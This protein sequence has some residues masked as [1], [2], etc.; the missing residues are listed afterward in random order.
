MPIHLS[1]ATA[2]AD[3]YISVSAAN[4]Y[5]LTRSGSEAW[6]KVVQ[7]S[8]GTL[9]A[10]SKK[11]RLLVQACREIDRS[12]RFYGAKYNGGQ[13]GDIDYQAMEFPRSGDINASG[14]PYIKQELKDAACEQVLWILERGGKRTEENG[15][16][17]FPA[18]IGASVTPLMRKLSTRVVTATGRPPWAGSDY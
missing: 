6:T 11:E 16:V 13:V 17:S 3:S 18:V 9:S 8:T 15:S 14:D 12:F 2:T 1:I 5:F 7:N 10:T 4:T